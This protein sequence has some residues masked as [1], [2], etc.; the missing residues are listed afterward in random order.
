MKLLLDSSSSLLFSVLLAQLPLFTSA[1]PAHPR[2]PHADFDKLTN[3]TRHLQKM[4][5][6]L[7]NDHKGEPVSDHHK[8][9]SLPAI[10]SRAN[11]LSNLEL[12]PTLSQLHADFRAF[13]HH[14]EW[15]NKLNQKHHHSSASKLGEMISHIR[16]L[17][18]LL[19]RQMLH[20]DAPR[21]AVPS[22]SLPPQASQWEMNQ[23][24]QVLLQRFRLFCDWAAR[25]LLSLKSKTQ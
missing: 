9:K 19:H 21:I 6:D 20:V 8:F 22:P 7:I 5:H 2:R 17:I 11:D 12:K 16:N 23:S 1:L 14:F 18:N 24:S 13:E 3:Q 4:T 10:N 25:A 15:L